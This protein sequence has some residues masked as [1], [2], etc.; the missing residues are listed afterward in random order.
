MYLWGE[1]SQQSLPISFIAEKIVANR[2][3][4]Y[5]KELNNKNINKLLSLR[6]WVDT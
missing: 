1:I 2:R 4:K 5:E 3:Y 6:I